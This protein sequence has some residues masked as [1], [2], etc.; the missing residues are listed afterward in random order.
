M[1]PEDP[2]AGCSQTIRGWDPGAPGRLVRL[3]ELNTNNWSS[4]L[5]LRERLLAG[6]DRDTG[7]LG[8]EAQGTVTHDLGSSAATTNDDDT[9]PADEPGPSVVTRI[10]H[11]QYRPATKQQRQQVLDLY[12]SGLSIHEIAQQV[13]V[14]RS[15][16]NRMCRDAGLSRKPRGNKAQRHQARAL[17]TQ[18]LTLAQVAREVGFSRSTI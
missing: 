7:Q 3:G 12:R 6:G 14:N 15:S 16:V 4:L 9:H 18:G 13:G 17:R 1:L 5:A 10:R 2:G 11:P 8:E